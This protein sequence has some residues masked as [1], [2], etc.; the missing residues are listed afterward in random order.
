MAAPRIS[1]RPMRLR[2]SCSGSAAQRRKVHTS[3]ATWLMV[4]GV[5]SSYSRTSL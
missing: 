3:L 1:F 5:P 2:W 4:A